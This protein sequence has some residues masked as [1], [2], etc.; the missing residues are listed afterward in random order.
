MFDFIK[1]LF[2][3]KAGS[4]EDFVET[5]KGEDCA[6]V[7]AE[8]YS[9]VVTESRVK[10][11]MLKLTAT[12]SRGRRVIYRECLFELPWD[13]P[14]LKG[15]RDKHNSIKSFLLGERRVRDLQATLPGVSVDLIGPKRRPMDDKAYVKLHQ[16]A[17]THGV[18]V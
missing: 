13:E 5:I 14:E 2:W 16:A 1:K 8:L 11:Y 18:S 15:A 6:G 12:M 9:V 10:Q 4:V 3:H 7:V 17:E